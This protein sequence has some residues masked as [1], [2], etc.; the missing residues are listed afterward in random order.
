M[1][2]V[3]VRD[4]V[5]SGVKKERI[6]WQARQTKERLYMCEETKAEEQR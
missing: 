2:R 1:S 5:P 4:L 6:E 3:K